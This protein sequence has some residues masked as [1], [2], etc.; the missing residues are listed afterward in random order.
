[1][2][3]TD[4]FVIF[5]PSEEGETY[6]EVIGRNELEERFNDGYYTGCVPLDLAALK[7]A[8][9]NVGGGVS[10][11]SPRIRAHGQTS[12]IMIFRADA[13]IVPKVVETVTRY[14]VN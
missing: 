11:D 2:S 9:G 1:M 5:M 4:E 12:S 6:L 14:E 7:L 13:M 3:T 10:V 8:G